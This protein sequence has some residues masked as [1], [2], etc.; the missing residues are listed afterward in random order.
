[1]DMVWFD[2]SSIL[3]LVFFNNYLFFS[4]IAFKFYC[5]GPCPI[6]HNNCGGPNQPICATNFLTIKTSSSPFAKEE[7]YDKSDSCKI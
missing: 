4:S 2:S 5:N 6:T 3:N 1:M 7:D